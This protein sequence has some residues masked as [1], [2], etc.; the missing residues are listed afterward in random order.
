MGEQ[1]MK[2]AVLA[3]LI[4]C[5]VTYAASAY[6]DQVETSLAQ[7]IIRLHVIANSDSEAD[8]QLKY[9]VR[10]RIVAETG[11]LFADCQTIGASRTELCKHLDR[12][13]QIAQEEVYAN[14]YDYPVT[15]EFGDSEFPTKV[16]GNVTLPA[17]TYE[18]LK[19]NIGSA[20]GQNWWC[21]LFPPLC[22]VDEATAEMPEESEQQLKDGMGETEYEMVTKTD[23]L[24]VEVR[25]KAYEMW[26]AGQMKLRAMFA[27]LN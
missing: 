11:A 5:V 25:F 21:V 20:Q 22:F 19:V 3:F 6:T 14:G 18:A 10:D 8:Q 2:K 7:G 26:Q 13:E 4:G 1:H 24:P 16:Y 9:K 17:G 23:E 15:V 27:R 12:I